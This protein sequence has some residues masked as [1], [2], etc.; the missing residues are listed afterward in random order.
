MKILQRQLKKTNKTGFTKF[1]NQKR[2]SHQ[3]RSAYQESLEKTVITRT[4]S[5]L[6]PQ[7]IFLTDPRLFNTPNNLSQHYFSSAKLKR[8]KNK[9]F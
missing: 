3:F 5:A 6:I 8:T 2:N 9:Q 4:F 7:T 1:T